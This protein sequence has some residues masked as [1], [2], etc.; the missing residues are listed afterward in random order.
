MDNIDI[1][2]MLCVDKKNMKDISIADLRGL[3]YKYGLNKHG[4]K[5]ELCTRIKSYINTISK[6]SVSILTTENE[7]K[8]NG[9]GDFLNL[10][11]VDNINE[12]HELGKDDIDLLWNSL[13][14][15][16]YNLVDDF[17]NYRQ[18]YPKYSDSDLKI[19]ILID[20]L[21][22][23]FCDC[24]RKDK[25]NVGQCDKSVLGN[26]GMRVSKFKCNDSASILLPKFGEKLI[27][28]KNNK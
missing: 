22:K 16:G 5:V 1:N 28:K 25:D 12:I 18:T 23:L 9:I 2:N 13:N 17:N 3:C 4:T 21:S 26:R 20:R 7:P 10:L 6:G 27:L 15:E 19:I 8:I 11:S 14:S 24:Y